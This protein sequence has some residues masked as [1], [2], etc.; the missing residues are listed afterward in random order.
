MGLLP[1]KVSKFVIRYVITLTK[2]FLVPPK[3][4]K[5]FLTHDIAKNQDRRWNEEKS[6]R[7]AGDDITVKLNHN[8]CRQQTFINDKKFKYVLVTN[9]V[10]RESDCCE[11]SDHSELEWVKAIE[12]Q[13]VFDFNPNTSED[14]L[15]QRIMDSKDVLVKPR[16]L[17]GI[18]Q[19]KYISR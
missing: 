4:L 1:V 12:W 14:G 19:I 2:I 9:D 17:P 13:A 10:C 18:E 11:M 6:T 16:I 15:A 5:S 3:K 8:L 7:E